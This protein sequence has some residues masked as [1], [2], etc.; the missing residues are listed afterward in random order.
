MYWPDTQT[1]VDVEPARKPVASAVRKFFT[2]GGL[3]QAPTVPGGDWFN[4]ITNELLNVLA[5]AGID[6]SK[7]DDDQLL[8]AIQKVS[9]DEGAYE[10]LRRSFADAGYS[11]RPK[12]ENFGNGGTLTSASDVLLD[13]TT[14]KAYSHSGPYPHPVAKGTSPTGPGFTDRSGAILRAAII[15]MS[16]VLTASADWSDIPAHSDPLLGGANGVLNAQARALAARTEQL[17][18]EKQHIVADYA[19]LRAYTGD[20]A[21]VYCMGR[22]NVFDRANGLFFLDVNNTNGVDDDGTLL[23]DTLGRRWQREHVNAVLPEW[24]GAKGDGVADD[25]SPIQKSFDYSRKVKRA[26]EFAAVTYRTTNTLNLTLGDHYSK[27][28]MMLRGAGKS[29]SILLL[30]YT[31]TA[32][33]ISQLKVSTPS[34]DAY[35]LEISHLGLSTTTVDAVSANLDVT[36]GISGLNMKSV[37]MSGAITSVYLKQNAWINSFVDLMMTPRDYGL[38]M[39]VS[40]TTNWFDECFVYGA[41]VCAYKL[42][43]DYSAIGSLAAD[44]CIGTVYDLRWF[45]GRIASLGAESPVKGRT[46]S[47]LINADN[48]VL[49]IGIV[50]GFRICPTDGTAFT[51]IYLGQGSVELTNITLDQHDQAD[52][53]LVITGKLIDGYRGNIRIKRCKTPKDGNGVNAGTL[54]FSSADPETTHFQLTPVD[55]TPFNMYHGGKP[56]MG[57]GKGEVKSWTGITNELSKRHCQNIYFDAAGSIIGSG[58]GADYDSLRDRWGNAP[59]QGSWFMEVDPGARGCAGYVVTVAGADMNS[60]STKRIPIVEVVSAL[61][62]LPVTDLWSGRRIFVQSTHKWVTYS[63]YGTAGWYDETGVKVA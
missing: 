18:L 51:G 17:R 1:G 46:P 36:V 53:N 57:M 16:G 52:A 12:P 22:S 61:G 9:T 19:A 28:G 59:T 10:A 24:W 39:E 63:T 8:L 21:Y 41:N 3:G 55:G 37:R 29:S 6:P 26:V 33:P 2:E 38:R 48:A 50:R 5:A 35:N 32:T 27:H 11:L 30:D 7:A 4:Q 13:T 56:Y 31:N 54:T 44:N 58:I 15:A 25:T 23:V 34:S 47:T 40:G 42:R 60:S 43:C 45:S 14:G 20:S 49:D 62:D